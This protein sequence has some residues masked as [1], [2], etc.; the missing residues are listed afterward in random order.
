MAQG[1][2]ERIE[3]AAGEEARL[4]AAR[5]P[6]REQALGMR[7]HVAAFGG[8]A[9]RLL[10]Q[11]LAVGPRQQRAEG[12]IA[13][14]PRAARHLEGA[15][16]QNFVVAGRHHASFTAVSASVESILAVIARSVDHPRFLCQ[17]KTVRDSTESHLGRRGPWAR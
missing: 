8:I 10:A 2:A 3:R 7:G 5:R 12:V 6:G 9:V 16:Q 15:A 17:N 1:S 11:H 14:R 13:V 4:M